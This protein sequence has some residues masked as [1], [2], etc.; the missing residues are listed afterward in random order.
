MYDQFRTESEY[1]VNNFAKDAVEPVLI[2]DVESLRKATNNAIKNKNV[3]YAYIYNKKGEQLEGYTKVSAIDGKIEISNLSTVK[4]IADFNGKTS[5]MDARVPVLYEGGEKIGYVR[6]GISL[7]EIKAEINQIMAKSVVFGIGF[8]SVGFIVTFVFSRSISNPI[9]NMIATIS[10]IVRH[11]DI[12]RI[13]RENVNIK[14]LD[15]LKESFNEMLNQ[16]QQRD[17]ALTKANEQLEIRVKERTAELTG[18]ITERKQAEKKIDNSQKLLQRIINLLPIRV[19][20]KDKNLRYLG[21]NEIFAKDAGKNTPEDLIGKDDFQMNWKEL[22]ERYRA[23]DQR[24][25]T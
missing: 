23:D 1:L 24:I 4:I 14:E 20:W 10:Y 5:V 7:E 22:A 25:I 11:N 12:T 18:E 13:I 17:L 3:V 2:E 9:K 16:I 19:F 6:L 15:K 21:C 8:L